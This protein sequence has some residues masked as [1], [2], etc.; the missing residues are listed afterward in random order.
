MEIPPASKD[1]GS[2]CVCVGVG[3]LLAP[4]GRGKKWPCCIC[5]MRP[6]QCRLVENK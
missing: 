3:G 5:E 2:V 6:Q 1:G 4:G